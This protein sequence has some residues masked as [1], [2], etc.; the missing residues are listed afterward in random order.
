[1]L[2]STP[3][4][5]FVL[6]AY[7]DIGLLKYPVFVFLLL[8][9]AAI[10]LSNLLLIAVISQS[11]S[12]HE[13]MF[14]FMCALFVNEVYGSTAIFPMLLSQI[15]HEAHVITRAACLL[16]IFCVYSY[17]GTEVNMLTLMS[18]DRYLAICCPLQYSSS[19]TPTKMAAL[20]TLCWSYS[21]IL[22]LF[23]TYGLTGRLKPCGN[24][25][26]KVYCDNFWVVRLSCSDTTADKIFGLVNGLCRLLC[27]ITLI[28][29]SYGRI[30][31][32]CLSS[33]KRARQTALGTCVP[34][35]LSILNFSC[36]GLFE[37]MQ[38]WFDMS[39]VSTPLRVFLSL[40]W[41]T[42]QPLASPVIYGLKMTKIRQAVLEKNS[43][44]DL[45]CCVFPPS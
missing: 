28:L 43:A 17:G 39:A 13:P 27:V 35:L 29:Y 24:V 16:Q 42:V 3:V 18:Y 19:M 1:M 41:L 23:I 26:D 36:G 7:M 25:I 11:R 20:I 5:H 10:L 9:Y 38:S 22:N 12:L 37:V 14:V 31:R 8:W 6:G 44:R 21:L 4:T 32:V 34:H 30:L 45:V 15:L 40:H 2:N 33:S